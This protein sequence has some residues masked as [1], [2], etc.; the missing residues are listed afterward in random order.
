MS[1]TNILDLNNRVGEL[2]ESYPASK[3]MLSDGTTS[4]EEKIG[5]MRMTKLWENPSPTS[6]FTA[7]NIILSSSDY[8]MLLVLS[9][10][11]KTSQRN[12]PATIGNKGFSIF[13]QGSNVVDTRAYDA[14]GTTVAFENAQ[15]N[16]S[17]NNAILI[18]YQIYGIK[19]T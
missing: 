10:V 2:A 1:T 6:D 8:D 12:A 18:P 9:R 5:N 4:V 15:R 13:C 11:S 3:V 14:S 17:N 7:Q 19:L 16:G